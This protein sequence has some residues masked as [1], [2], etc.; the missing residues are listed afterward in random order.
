MRAVPAREPGDHH[1]DGAQAPAEEALQG[2]EV[3]HEVRRLVADHKRAALC[4]R[5]LAQEVQQE[6]LAP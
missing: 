1:V 2:G 4:A 3:Q 6:G 5:A